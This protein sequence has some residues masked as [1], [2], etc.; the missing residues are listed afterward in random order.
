M[1]SF[2]TLMNPEISIQILR[3]SADRKALDMSDI[4]A[5]IAYVKFSI[6]QILFRNLPFF[7]NLLEIGYMYCKLSRLN[8]W[9]WQEIT[10]RQAKS[11][12]SGL[13][14]VHE[15]RYCYP[16]GASD[17]ELEKSHLIKV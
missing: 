12:L 8:L 11:R 1:D 7:A 4:L 6:G 10:S 15:I 14:E 17:I 13:N 5:L 16:V 2:F 9:L 3:V